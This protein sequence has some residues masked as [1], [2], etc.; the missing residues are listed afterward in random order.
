MRCSVSCG[1]TNFDPLSPSEDEEELCHVLGLPE[2]IKEFILFCD[3]EGSA[4]NCQPQDKANNKTTVLL[5]YITI[6]VIINML[7]HCL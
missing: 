1:Q 7:L 6:L 3:D 2:Q 5:C 4:H